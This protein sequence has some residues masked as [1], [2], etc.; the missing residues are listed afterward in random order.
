MIPTV[1]QP[2]DQN[3]T[4][5]YWDLFHKDNCK[6]TEDTL[7]KS[8]LIKEIAELVSKQGVEQLF[9]S[10]KRNLYFLNNLSPTNH[11]FMFR[12]ICHLKTP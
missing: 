9:S 12:P 11:L 2:Q 7:R 8:S 4:F 6:K 10:F 1:I 3:Y 5:P